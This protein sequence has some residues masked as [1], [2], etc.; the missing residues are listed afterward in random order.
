MFEWIEDFLAP[1]DA[2]T[3]PDWLAAIGTVGAFASGVWIYQKDLR[4]KREA[5][6]RQIFGEI[7]QQIFVHEG[8]S[9]ETT[10]RRFIDELKGRLGPDP[11]TAS[12]PKGP[13][14]YLAKQ[15][16]CI[17][18]IAV[19]N[20]S[21]L[22]ISDVS[23]YLT[24]YQSPELDSSFGDVPLVRPSKTKRVEVIYPVNFKTTILPVWPV[25]IFTDAT[26]FMWKREKL[27]T[28]ERYRA[29]D[30]ETPRMPK[31]PRS[32]RRRKPGPRRV[33]VAT[34]RQRKKMC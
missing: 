2:G 34:R 33:R 7:D 26:G 8:D 5:Q 24:N 28:P 27:D 30:E 6:A 16:L 32:V 4:E 19:R 1:V 15:S 22:G 25:I 9:V 31:T 21:G 12:K 23:G 17:V 14:F 20:T 18:T 10:E 29:G 11:S 3:W 13:Y